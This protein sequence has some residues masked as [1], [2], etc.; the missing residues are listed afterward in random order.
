MIFGCFQILE[1]ALDLN[2]DSLLLFVSCLRK[3]T[4]KESLHSPEDLDLASPVSQIELCI[5]FL[6]MAISF[7]HN[8][9]IAHVTFEAT[10]HGAGLTSIAKTI[11]NTLHPRRLRKTQWII[12]AKNAQMVHVHSF[13]EYLPSRKKRNLHAISFRSKVDFV[14]VCGCTF[15][16]CTA[17]CCG[18][19]K[20]LQLHLSSLKYDQA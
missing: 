13:P 7:H 4:R 2:P 16:H 8:S 6:P 1:K 9:S 10:L 5:E 11:N 18:G 3:P 17:R 12:I 15:G 19:V 20:A 14:G